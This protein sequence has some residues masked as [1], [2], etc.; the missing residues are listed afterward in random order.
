MDS[1]EI[2]IEA[3]ALAAV[4]YDAL[5]KYTDDASYTRPAP[6]SLRS[7]SPLELL[8]RM[9]ADA[10]LRSLF[11]SPGYANL[12]P[13]FAEHEDLVLEYWNA[14][15]LFGADERAE[16]D[17]GARFAEAQETAVVLLLAATSTALG[18]GEGG[19]AGTHSFYAVHVLT[20]SHAVRAVLGAAPAR[21]HAGLVRQWWLLAVAVYAALRC[22][23]IDAKAGDTGNDGEDANSRKSWD[24]VVDRALNGP[25][26]TDAHYVKGKRHEE[27]PPPSLACAEVLTPAFL[28][29]ALRAMR[30][31]A[32]AWGD[33]DGRYLA[34][35]VRFADGFGGWI[36]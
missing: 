17:P 30:D 29:A 16:P 32:Q 18:V 27:T 9:A 10:R 28:P 19:G 33:P 6:P 4:Q 12:A 24:H 7:R 31:A 14:W 36:H 20:T 5:H 11:P 15:D 13:L 35:A 22:P 25:Y 34:A 3:L 2:A 21:F 8:A 1:K 26:A 23:P